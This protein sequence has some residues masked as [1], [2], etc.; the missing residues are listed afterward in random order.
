MIA[1][2]ILVTPTAAVIWTNP[3][4]HYVNLAMLNST[5]TPTIVRLS[6]TPT[7]L[8]ASSGWPLSPM[9]TSP[10]NLRLAPGDSL[11][12]CANPTQ[13]I[14]ILARDEPA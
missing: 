2:Q 13:T 1:T 8:S 9:S 14:D 6:G 12:A 7:G 4:Q 10:F 5:G 3:G 11:A